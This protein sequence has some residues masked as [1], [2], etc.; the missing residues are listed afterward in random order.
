MKPRPAANPARTGVHHLV[1]LAAICLICGLVPLAMPAPVAAQAEVTPPPG[2]PELSVTFSELNDSGVSGIATLYGDGDQTIVSIRV[3][4][5]GPNH[6]AHIHAG[7]CSKLDPYPAF[8]LENVINGRST[9]IVDASLDELLAG[10]YS[11]DLHMSVNELGTLV[12]CAPIQGTPT[13]VSTP[14]DGTNGVTPEATSTEAVPSPTA[15]ATEEP[16][17][18]PTTEPEGVGGTGTIQGDGTGGAQMAPEN[19]ASL[20]LQSLDDLG[21]TGTASITAIDAEQTDIQILLTGDLV[22]GGHLAHLHRGT[23][24]DDLSNDYTLDLEPVDATGYSETIVD[25]PFEELLTGGYA[26]NVHASE[27]DYDTWFVCG[28]FNDATVGAVIPEVAPP[29]GTGLEPTAAPTPEPTKVAGGI[30]DL[31]QTAGSGTGL[32]LPT[33]TAGLTLW[34]MLIFGT[35]LAISAVAVRRGEHANRSSQARRRRLGL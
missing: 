8:P 12:V 18:E 14:S 30:S 33:S 26:I 34:A 16:D 9:S 24:C 15:E 11:I 3:D 6:P 7:D 21:V 2:A 29:T 17:V 1:L 35:I 31:P 23:S 4:D 5:A 32:L 19:T 25:I 13:I 22:T 10:E 20:P 28:T 27:A